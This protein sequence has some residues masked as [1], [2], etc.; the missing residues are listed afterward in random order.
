MIDIGARGVRGNHE[1]WI[2]QWTAGEGL[3]EMALYMGGPATLESYGVDPTLS[4]PEIEEAHESV[5]A[6]HR[7]YFASLPCVMDL[8]VDDE[9]YWLIHAGLPAKPRIMRDDEIPDLARSHRI[10]LLWS[11]TPTS[12]MSRV[13]STVIYGHVPDVEPHDLGAFI[14]IDTGAGRYPDTGRLTAVVLPERR[15]VTVGP[16]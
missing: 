9:R 12:E 8:R 13:D 11:K 1:E 4:I 15:F 2:T 6:S 16:R 3:D 10:T 14:G 7:A 5:P